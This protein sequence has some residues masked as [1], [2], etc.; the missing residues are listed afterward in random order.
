MEKR[1]KSRGIAPITGKLSGY[2]YLL[3]LSVVAGCF[4]RFYN[5]GQ[6]SL[7]VDETASYWFSS[8]TVHELWTV[9]AR[10]ETNPPLYYTML[11][12]W[13][14][15]F[16][17]S[18]AGIRSLSAVMSMGC[19]PLIFM[20]GR[21]MGNPVEGGWIGAIAALMFAVFPVHIQY[22]QE[23]RAYAM[24]TF[25]TT[26][27][28][29]TFLWIVRHPAEA[30]EPL[31]GN[32][33]GTAQSPDNGSWWF[34]SLPWMTVI[35]S[36]T[37]TLW[38]HATSVLYVFILFL[39]MLAWYFLHLRC[40]RTFLINMS[41]TAVVIF[42]LWCPY[43]NFLVAQS[44]HA[45]LPIAKPT[46]RTVIDTV[47]W[48]FFGLSTSW[49]TSIPNKILSELFFLV[50]II[51]SIAGLLHIRRR[52]GIYAT[53]LILLA[54]IGPILAELF[55]SLTLRPI[56][57][58]RTLVYVSVPFFITI[59]AGIMM[60]DGPKKRVLAT[61]AIATFFLHLSYIYHVKDEKESNE[62]WDKIVQTVDKQGRG[63]M[64]LLVPN[65]LE[66]PF[67]YYATRISNNTIPIRP[68]PLPVS[69]SVQKLE[70]LDSRMLPADIA[71]ISTLIAG[72][73]PVWLITR[74]EDLYDQNRIVYNLL[75]QKKSLVSSRPFGDI[76]VFRF[77]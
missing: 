7:W 39:V 30:C 43:L 8:K 42:L 17:S 66:V 54:I 32:I 62:P 36:V 74:R 48:L 6:Q 3:I 33:T 22:A 14:N 64:V 76:N 56:F 57:L 31:I 49:T 61:V 67:T 68:L 50:L 77:N 41:V 1:M 47:V 40:N 35:L 19:I 23:A 69:D 44:M 18:E 5:I 27:T 25:A 13:R 58:A 2:R 70:R 20:I 63:D 52:S 16:G 75:R 60:M 55:I 4:L 65:Y 11:K 28:L 45:S 46:V 10:F 37:F 53:L 71:K 29:C 73:S 26:L 12:F 38:L 59:A 15:F 51:L 34:R 72:N 21:K 24:L 9:I